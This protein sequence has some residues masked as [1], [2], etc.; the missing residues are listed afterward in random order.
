MTVSIRVLFAASEVYPLVKTGGLGDVGYSLPHA[1]HRAGADVRLVL[2]AYRTVLA[3]VENIRILGW[4]EVRGAKRTHSVRILEVRHPDFAFPLWLVDCQVLFD[5]P[6]NPYVR[7]DGQDW[8]DNAERFTV[9]ARAVTDLARDVLGIHWQAD[10]VHANDWQTG[11]VPALLGEFPHPPKR[12]FTIHNMAYG[13]HFSLADFNRL[14]LPLHWWTHEGVEFYGG[15]SMLKAGIV[16]ADEVTTVS[17]TYAREICTSEFGYGLHG[18]LQVY[19][20]KLHGILNGIDEAVWDPATDA[21]LPAHYSAN[22]RQ[23]GKALNKQALLARFGMATD[24]LAMQVPLFGMVSRLV[25]QKGLD[26]VLAALP[27]W[28]AHTD[29]RFVFVGSGDSKYEA[30]LCEFAVGYPH[31]IGVCIGYDEALAHLV[32]AGSDL[33]LMPSQFEPCGLNQ[34]YSLRYGTP[35]VV[36]RTGGLAD[37]VI[38]ASMEHQTQGIANGFVFDKFDVETLI[39]TVERAIACYDQP[40]LWQALL[41]TGMKHSFGWEHS[42]Q[43]YLALY[44]ATSSK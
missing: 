32:E 30:S 29:A 31:R 12:I 26:L 19:R 42:A 18:V 10:V 24:D 5:R 23:P 44:R 37:T 21:Y 34:M 36:Y 1:L 33:F 41:R 6:G 22:R 7:A 4:L 16:Y 9:F 3:Q 13:G 38:D 43:S 35:P 39:A 28:L 17:P 14:A 20:H 11:L 27:H 40:R 15:F 25:Q 8:P 2:P